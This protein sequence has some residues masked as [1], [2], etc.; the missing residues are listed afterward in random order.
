MK[1]LPFCLLPALLFISVASCMAQTDAPQVLREEIE[2]ANIWFPHVRDTNIPHVLLIGDS[3]TNN[4][5]NFVEKDMEGKASIARIA[6]S[7]FVSDPLLPDLLKLYLSRMKFDVIQFNNG[8]HGWD[9]SEDE[10]R[11]AFPA[12]LAAIVDNA[13]GAKLI[14]AS[15]TPISVPNHPEQ[16]DP[17]TERVKARNAI[18]HEFVSKAGIPEDD[19]FTL[20][21]AHP[22]LHDAGGIHFTRAGEEM[23][24][25][26]VSSVIQKTLSGSP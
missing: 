26:Q 12:F 15:T 6:T 10:Y 23:Q 5:Y 25:A 13:K 19:L 1:S 4:Y 11:A 20:M 18:A 14:W 7:H 2:W 21:L 3:I 22:E 17:R 9:H 16:I 8:M 24:G